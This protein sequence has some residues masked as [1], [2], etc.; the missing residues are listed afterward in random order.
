MVSRTST[1]SK[2]IS[3]LG[4]SLA[5]FIVTAY[6]TWLML[7]KMNSIMMYV[8]DSIVI[9]ADSGLCWLIW[10][11]FSSYSARNDLRKVAICAH[12]LGAIFSA[13]LFVSTIDDPIAYFGLYVTAIS[14]FH[15]SEYL[16]TALYNPSTLSTDSYL[17][18][19]SSAYVCAMVS[20]LVEY[21]LELCFFPWIKSFVWISR[22]G[23]LLV[24]A[25]ELLRKVAMITAASNFTHQVQCF[26]RKDHTLVTRGVYSLSRHPSYV[27][28]FYWSVGS[29][30]LLC[31]PVCFVG[32]LVATWKFFQDR[33]WD[34]ELLL[35]QFFG[36]EYEDY[37]TKVGIGI[38]FIQGYKLPV[39]TT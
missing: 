20:S 17:I 18:N 14:L 12:G 7:Q 26:K 34:E 24:V 38:P 37:R 22:L 39:A 30:L 10:T 25:G 32:F 6:C 21:S 11:K 15:M 33:I 36:Q 3:A 23:L 5:S 16:L 1:M 27:G 2:A 19:H 8:A 28:W 13:G 29:Q 35:L 9:L 4:V 31:N